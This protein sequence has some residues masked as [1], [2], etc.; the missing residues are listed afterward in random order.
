MNG[1]ADDPLVVNGQPLDAAARQRLAPYLGTVDPTALAPA[2]TC[3]TS[4]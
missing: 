3:M 2:R 1:P 4:V